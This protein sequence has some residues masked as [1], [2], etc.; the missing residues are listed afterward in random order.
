MIRFVVSNVLSSDSSVNFFT[1]RSDVLVNNSPVCSGVACVLLK[2]YVVVG[3]CGTGFSTEFP[4]SV[5]S[6]LYYRYSME[7]LLCCW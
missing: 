2:L 7:F 3:R 5:F 4:L 6:A 1:I